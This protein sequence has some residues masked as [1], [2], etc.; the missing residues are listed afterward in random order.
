M[1]RHTPKWT[2]TLGNLHRTIAK[3]KTHWIEKFFIS[4]KSSWNL[5][6]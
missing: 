1:N 2:P 6:F 4:L 3:D 5:N